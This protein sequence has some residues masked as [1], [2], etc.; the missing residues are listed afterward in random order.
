[1]ANN[2]RKYAAV[3]RPRTRLAAAWGG[4]AYY[5]TVEALLQRNCVL[6]ASRGGHYTLDNV[7]PACGPCNASKCGAEI[8][9]GQYE[10]RAC[11]SGTM[12]FPHA[13]LYASTL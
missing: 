6:A 10:R 5:R 7:A 12:G 2:S 4:V 8:M 13:V 1:M 9:A 3:P 11:A